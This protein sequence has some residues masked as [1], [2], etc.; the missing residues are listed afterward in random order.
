[1]SAKLLVQKVV[2]SLP[3]TLDPNTIYLVRVGVGFD[4]YVSD[5]LGQIA[6]KSN[7]PQSDFAQTN[8]AAVDFIKNKPTTLAGYGITDAQ[9]LDGDLTTIAG[10]TGTAGLLRKTAA[11]TWELDTTEV[12]PYDLAFDAISTS[13][14]LTKAATPV[15]NISL[16]LVESLDGSVQMY[17]VKAPTP[18]V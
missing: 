12:D 1:M 15:A 10:L 3:A 11:N 14:Q 17:I 5:S 4:L 13:I 7:S 16:D 18:V 2:S 9:P 6:H 8:T